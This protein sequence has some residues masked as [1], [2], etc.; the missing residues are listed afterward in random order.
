MA[1]ESHVSS[2]KISLS[3]AKSRTAA[4]RGRRAA[5]TSG[6]SRSAAWTV[7][8]NV[9]PRAA[10][11]RHTVTGEA[12]SLGAAAISVGVINGEPMLDLPYSEDS[13]AE[14]DMNVVM[15]GS[16]EFIEIQGTAEQQPFDRDTLNRLLDLAAGGCTTLAE[17]QR[18]ALAS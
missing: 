17:L 13:V 3:G 12:A 16:G 9:R 11:V 18:A 4:G 5:F 14:V 2:R 1:V 7:I 6:R 10:S 8:F 15:S